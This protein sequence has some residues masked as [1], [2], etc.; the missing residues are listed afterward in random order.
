MSKKEIVKL[1]DINPGH[2]KYDGS[3]VYGIGGVAPTIAARDY[4]GAKLILFLLATSTK[5]A[6][7]SLD[8]PIQKMDLHQQ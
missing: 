6:K 1:G 2:N 5:V 7:D 4:K 3:S 8:S